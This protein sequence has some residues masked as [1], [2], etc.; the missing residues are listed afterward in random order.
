MFPDFLFFDPFA[1][2]VAVV[3]AG[4]VAT[5]GVVVGAVEVGAGAAAVGA[6]G[7]AEVG[8]AGAVSVLVVGAFWA[9]ATPTSKDTNVTAGTNNAR[10]E[11]LFMRNSDIVRSAMPKM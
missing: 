4:S 6:A 3:A 2:S 9:S 1:G 5:A 10:W 11:S 8:G 7:V